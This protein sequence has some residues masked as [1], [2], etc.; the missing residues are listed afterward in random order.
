MGKLFNQ[1]S[2]FFYFHHIMIQICRPF[3]NR[4]S[5]ETME[6]RAWLRQDEGFMDTMRAG[7][8]NAL[9]AISSGSD[10]IDDVAAKIPQLGREIMMAHREL[11]ANPQDFNGDLI[12]VI[13][14]MHQLG[15]AN[16]LTQE[17]QQ[18]MSIKDAGQ[19]IAAWQ[20]S[21]VRQM[22]N[23]ILK[24]GEFLHIN[25]IIKAM[26][27]QI[28]N[29][30]EKSI[31]VRD[32]EGLSKKS[33]AIIALSLA[34]VE[35]LHF[36]TTTAFISGIMAKVALIGGHFGLAGILGGGC[37]VA[38]MFIIVVSMVYKKSTSKVLRWIL[39]MILSLIS[40]GGKDEH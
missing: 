15:D 35:F 33:M 26:P 28:G 29:L 4:Y 7:A 10:W 39:G 2:D 30:W 17:A 5:M 32:S 23:F 11:L 25:Q 14:Q 20:A 19:I 16:S 6:F 40:P 38:W 8:T 9:Q 36:L 1:G 37:Y 3:G 31:A 12:G 21:K 27:K 22:V 13:K 34:V 18:I 24:I